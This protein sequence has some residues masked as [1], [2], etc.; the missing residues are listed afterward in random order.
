[1]GLQCDAALIPDPAGLLS[2]FGAEIEAL[3]ELRR[4]ARD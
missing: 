4:Q 1:M 3:D 2:G